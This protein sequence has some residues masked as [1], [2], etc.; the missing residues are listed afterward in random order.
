MPTIL[1]LMAQKDGVTGAAA[2]PFVS[3]GM[4]LWSLGGVFGFCC[5]GFIADLI[6]RRFAVML[7]SSAVPAS[8]DAMPPIIAQSHRRV[9]RRRPI[10]ND[11]RLSTLNDAGPPNEAAARSNPHRR[12]TTRQRPAGSFLG[13]FRTATPPPADRSRRAGIRNPSREPSFASG[14][15]R[16]LTPAVVPVN[17]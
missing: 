15:R 3:K 4:M 13:G 9:Q 6:G 12:R 7:Y 11:G 8:A 2:V 17:R 10:L 1:S 14:P 16:M 5:H